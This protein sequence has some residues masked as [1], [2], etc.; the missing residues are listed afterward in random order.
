MNSLD[1]LIPL[2]P[3]VHHKGEGMWQEKNPIE[4]EKKVKEYL[5]IDVNK[6]PP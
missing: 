4:F 3:S 2:C 1:N 6:K 5:N